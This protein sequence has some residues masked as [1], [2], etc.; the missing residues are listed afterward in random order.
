MVIQKHIAIALLTLCG[1]CAWGQTTTVYSYS[2]P[3]SG[4]Y[5][6]NGNLMNYTDSVNG[7]WGMQYDQLNRLQ[8]AAAT[9]GPYQSL[10]LQMHYDSFGNRTYQTPTGSPSVSV[11]SSWANYGS[12]NQ[13]LNSNM[14][15][16]GGILYDSPDHTA[17]NMTFD[18]VNHL[19]YD[20]E[21]RVCAVLN[22][23][24]GSITQYL[25]NAEG[26]RVAKGHPV[27][28]TNTLVCPTG[29]S[30]FTP[31]ET[32][33]LGPT[34]EQVTQ[35]DGSG[36]W[37]HTNVYA[38]GQLLAT[39]DSEVAPQKQSVQLLHFNLS[40]PL[41]TKRIQISAAG[42]VELSCSSLP[43]G[44]ALSCNGTTQDATQHHFTGK[45]RDQ[46]SQLDYFGARYYSSTIGRMMS[47]D[48]S[49]LSYADPTNPQ[50]LN[51]YSYVL[52]NPLKFTDP[53]G[54]ACVWDDGSFDSED[55]KQTGSSRQCSSAGGTWLDKGATGS[56]SGGQDWSNK[57]D[58]Y[59]A[60]VAFVSRNVYS[61]GPNLLEDQQNA[62]LTQHNLAAMP[63]VSDSISASAQQF[64]G[65]VAQNT[66]GFPNICNASITARVAIP[67]T[68]LAV[69]PSVDLNGN[70]SV[71]AR[72]RQA[73]AS[74]GPQA[75]LT[76][77][78]SKVSQQITVPIPD[79]P[80]RA[81]ISSGTRPSVG[82]SSGG[83]VGLSGSATFGTMG[84]PSCQKR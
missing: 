10:T 19:A 5:A 50:S 62:A 71:S 61:G 74:D 67:G 24:T 40:D 49:G 70:V 76:S 47:P 45:E 32:Y 69:G 1:A 2:V 57:S 33:I 3:S 51:L 9:T 84:D 80:F 15:P 28:S 54:M 68:P 27:G 14:V 29:A 12:N 59:I 72:L 8:S 26:L 11:P 58:S 66:A 20:A 4:G 16:G 36:N 52:N 37:Q 23:N 7:T 34:G 81:T 43:Y 31:T 13:V 35:L 64:I 44:E 83:L 39:Y 42:V 56:L 41:G 21:N 75:N 73:G 79:T 55:D 22:T 65:Q 48:P 6:P 30:D 78:G 60:G 25:Y 53:S 63:T 77:N 46:E 18:G 38:A 82:V 17:G